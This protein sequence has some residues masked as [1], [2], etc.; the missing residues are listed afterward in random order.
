MKRQH[1]SIK[2]YG[3]VGASLKKDRKSEVMAA[4]NFVIAN[5]VKRITC[6]RS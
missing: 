6:G 4:I 5:F 3:N 2:D 1:Q